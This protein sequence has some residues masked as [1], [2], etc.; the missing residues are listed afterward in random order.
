LFQG[1]GVIRVY[2]KALG[3][4]PDTDSPFTLFRGDTVADLALQVHRE[5]AESLKFAKVWG[6]GQFDGQQVGSDHQLEDKDIV[7]LHALN[8]GS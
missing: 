7:E 3:K 6:S 8:R 1:L 2:T 4:D 5:I